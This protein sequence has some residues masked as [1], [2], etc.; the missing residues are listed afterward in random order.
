LNIVTQRSPRIELEK[1]KKIHSRILSP[2]CSPVAKQNNYIEDD[3]DMELK[4]ITCL[5]CFA[6][7]YLSCLLGY[8]YICHSVLI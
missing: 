1:L 2:V 5:R 8:I 3:A 7:S 6:D 4:V